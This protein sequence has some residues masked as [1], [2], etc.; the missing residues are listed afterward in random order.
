MNRISAWSF[1]VRRPFQN[2]GNQQTGRGYR[3]I[4]GDSTKIKI[5]RAPTI[6]T[7]TCSELSA[8]PPSIW[9]KRAYNMVIST[10]VEI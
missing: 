7:V 3:P 1:L 4:R 2:L 8:M 10:I 6:V 5:K 9:R